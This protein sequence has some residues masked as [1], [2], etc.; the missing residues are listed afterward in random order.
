MSV[1]DGGE[2]IGYSYDDFGVFVCKEGSGCVPDSTSRTEYRCM[3]IN[4]TLENVIPC[5]GYGDTSCPAG[6]H[7]D[8]NSIT[9]TMQCVPYPPNNKNIV[10]HYKK[11]WEF[12]DI[13]SDDARA[14][15][16]A[17]SKALTPY[18]KD[19]HCMTPLP[20]PPDS[21]SSEPIS[22]TSAS[23]EPSPASASSDSV[24]GGSS[25]RKPLAFSLVLLI[26]GLIK[27]FF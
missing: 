11:L 1:E 20:L 24:P 9:G 5:T 21:A 3:K 2:C 17:I 4:T 13:A 22:S 6:S 27:A 18:D 25:D 15:M 23:S 19:S 26:V 10:E 16:V 12:D 14:Y 8:C 7:C